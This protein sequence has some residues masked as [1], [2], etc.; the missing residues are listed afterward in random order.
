MNCVVIG[1]GCPAKLDKLSCSGWGANT[2][3]TARKT[4]RMAERVSGADVEAA[5][6]VVIVESA[7][8]IEVV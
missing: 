1:T 4:A 3:A 2:L 6:A 8:T 5:T 7:A